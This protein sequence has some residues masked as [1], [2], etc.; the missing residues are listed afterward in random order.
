MKPAL[1][2][3]QLLDLPASVEA[4][5]IAAM[6]EGY[7]FV[8]KLV[9]EWRSGINRFDRPGEIF[10]GAFQS[11]DPVAVGGLNRDPYAKQDGVARLRHVYV[12][13]AFRHCGVGTALVRRLLD[14]A[15]GRFQSVRLRTATPESAGFYVRL[16]FAP[17][18]E[19]AA[20]HIR[21]LQR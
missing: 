17:V 2:I 19:E 18:Q 16:G 13:R 10:L 4:L 21:V 5:R 9:A 15:T 11:D 6:G 20:T 14:E 7:G 1:R 12:A 8:D 3:V